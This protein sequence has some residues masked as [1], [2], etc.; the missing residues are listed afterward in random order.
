MKIFTQIAATVVVASWATAGMALF[1]GE[2]F[3]GS[4]TSSVKYT[5]AGTEKTKD[6]KGTEMGATFLLDPIP[7]VPVAFGVTVSQGNTDIK[8]VA[9]L[10][11]DDS[12]TSGDLAGFSATGTG[13]SKTMFYGP[14]IKVWVPMPIIH[15]YLKAGYLMGAEVEDLNLSFSSPA[16]SPVATKMVLKPK[17]TYTH[18]ATEVTVG[19]GYSPVKLTRIFAEY[20]MHTGKRK[21]KSLSGEVDMD[22]DGTSTSVPYATAD[23]AAEDKK[24]KTADAK[25]IRLGVSV[26]I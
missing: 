2:V 11:A 20:S 4:R 21:A 5:T 23:L 13:T 7:L 8:D 19:V 25:S 9:Q 15:P 3:Y 14:V 10:V 18:T 12:T 6:L 16:D 17:T 26:G 22:V 24:S 1:D